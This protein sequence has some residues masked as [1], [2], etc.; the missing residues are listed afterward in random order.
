MKRGYSELAEQSVVCEYEHVYPR[1]CVCV[2]VCVTVF[3]SDIVYKFDYKLYNSAHIRPLWFDFY[4]TDK[5][6]TMKHTKHFQ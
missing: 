1:V 5:T 2:C 6:T 4:N 3:T